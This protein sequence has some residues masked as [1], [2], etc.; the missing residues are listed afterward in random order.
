LRDPQEAV[1]RL[2]SAAQGL[3]PTLGPVLFQL[4]PDLESQP[5]RL[6]DLL[7]VLPDSMRA[8]FE[9]RHRSW[10]SSEIFSMLDSSG[11]AL[12]WADS[13]G[14]RL[15][16]PVTA[17]WAYVRFHRGRRT[18]PGYRWAKLT[19]WAD[20]LVAA[21]ATDVFAYFNNDQDAAAVHDAQP[22]SETRGSVSV[23][24]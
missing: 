19:K 21:R 20:R 11:A 22:S 16:L 15:E 24:R 12:V 7:Q 9:F 5:D 6:H 10:F 8:A 3:G 2:W 1:A 18:S 23:A 13:P 4:P 14:R 17:G